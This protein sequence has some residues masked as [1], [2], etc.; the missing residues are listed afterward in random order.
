MPSKTIALF[1]KTIIN[2]S[3]QYL[4]YAIAQFNLLDLEIYFFMNKQKL[5]GVG[6]RARPNDKMQICSNSLTTKHSFS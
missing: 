3:D 6:R 1:L 4:H 2:Q 5:C